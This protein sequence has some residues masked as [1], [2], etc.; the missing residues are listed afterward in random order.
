MAKILT[1]GEL[2]NDIGND[3]DETPKKIA[4]ALGVGFMND[5]IPNGRAI[6]LRNLVKNASEARQ[7]LR[8][9]VPEAIKALQEYETKQGGKVVKVGCLVVACCVAP[10]ALGFD[11][12]YGLQ[13]KFEEDEK[14]E[15]A[16]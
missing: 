2:L 8:Q 15:K 4:A 1:V 11:F 5:P 6:G 10:E 3:L 7:A 9:F 13:F 16:E 14:D 12:G